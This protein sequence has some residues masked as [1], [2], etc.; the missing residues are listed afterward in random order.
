MRNPNWTAAG[1][2]LTAILAIAGC[3][4]SQSPN[5]GSQAP[6]EAGVA[7][8]TNPTPYAGETSPGEPFQKPN[9]GT[10]VRTLPAGQRLEVVFLDDVSSA[11]NKAGDSFRARVNSDVSSNGSVVVPAGSVIVGTVTEAVPLNKRFGG[12]SKLAV[13]FDRLELPSGRSVP[14]DARL[15]RQGSSET[16]KDVAEVL[17]GAVAGAFA[18]RVLKGRGAAR[19][20][21][22]VGA[23]AGTAVAMT[24]KGA[25]VSI[26]SGTDV[27]LTLRSPVDVPVT[28]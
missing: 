7:G 25:N 11:R 1:V 3:S 4:R 9:Q 6:G 19:I 21:A 13:T 2:A 5:P 28:L 10:E 23:A 14:I 8:Q 27:T 16:K 15:A 22:V 26:P 12:R 18:G 20:G 17:G 24:T